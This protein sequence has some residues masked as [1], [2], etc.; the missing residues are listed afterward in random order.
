MWDKLVAEANRRNITVEQMIPAMVRATVFNAV[1]LWHYPIYESPAVPQLTAS[2]TSHE[3]EMEAE[4]AEDVSVATTSKAGEG[5]QA[6][7]AGNTAV[8]PAKRYVPLGQLKLA[9][10]VLKNYRDSPDT[11]SGD[12]SEVLLAEMYMDWALAESVSI[13]GDSLA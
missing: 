12:M 7:A 9:L 2:V 3:D 6:Q 11:S 13:K 4:T 5:S 1:A 8:V 10:T